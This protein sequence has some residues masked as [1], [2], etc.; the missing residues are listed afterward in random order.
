MIFYFTFKTELMP[1]FV[2]NC[3][4]GRC[5]SSPDPVLRLSVPCTLQWPE[6]CEFFTCQVQSIVFFFSHCCH[7]LYNLFCTCVQGACLESVLEVPALWI[8]HCPD[9]LNAKS[10]TIEKITLQ[11]HFADEH[12]LMAPV[13]LFSVEIT[14][15]FNKRLLAFLQATTVG[16]GGGGWHNHR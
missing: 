2:D 7:F 12:A 13:P 16:M 15:F 1:L 8:T 6:S 5:E 11:A 14:A 3:F 10:K 9:Y 4:Q